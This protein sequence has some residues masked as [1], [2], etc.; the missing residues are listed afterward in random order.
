MSIF[1]NPSHETLKINLKNLR[2][3]NESINSSIVI[4]RVSGVTCGEQVELWGFNRLFP[5]PVCMTWTLMTTTG[6]NEDRLVLTRTLVHLSVQ[7]LYYD[8]EIFWTA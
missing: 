7:W 6:F 2:F 5:F 4:F 1:M 8:L 3:E